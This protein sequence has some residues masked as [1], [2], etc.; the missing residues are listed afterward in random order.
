[1]RRL[2]GYVLMLIAAVTL[3]GCV[4]ATPSHVALPLKARDQIVSTEVV[5][6]IG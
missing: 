4:S 5:A 2:T 3:E 1:M 6:P